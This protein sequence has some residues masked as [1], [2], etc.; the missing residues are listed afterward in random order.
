[1]EQDAYEIFTKAHR[2]YIKGIRNAISERLKSAY[3]DD[4]WERG[5]LPALGE[6]HRENL[7]RELEK[8][9]PE[10]V[11]EL[12][13]TT[14]F[15]RIVQRNHAMA[16]ADAF[17]NIDY[18][19]RLF[20]YISATRNE[21]AHV[22]DGQWTITATMHVVQI[23]R[24]ILISLRRKE[25][26]E[27]HRMFR[28]SLDQQVSIPE[29][30]LN[31][32]EEPPPDG[33]F[34]R[35]HS[36]GE[37]SLL[38]FWRALESYLVVESIVQP[39]SDDTQDTGHVTIL[40]K[41]TNTSPVSEGRPYIR[42][43][44]VRLETTGAEGRNRRGTNRSEWGELV[45]GQTVISECR[46]A[47]KGLAAVEFRVFGEVDL[48]SLF[49]VQRRNTLPQ[50]VVTPLLEQLGSQF[51]GVGIEDILNRVV[52][53]V[54]RIQPDMTL[55]EVSALRNELGHLKPLI[56]EKRE[57]L[58][59]FF[60]EYHISQESALGTPLREVI[61]L[62]EELETRKISAM[63]NAIGETDLESIQSVVLEIEQ[64][65]ISVL[66]AREAVRGRLKS[67]TPYPSVI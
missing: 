50:E 29:E 57:T 4:W 33:D 53:T 22:R 56:A 67:Q 23:M 60:G 5:V 36:V 32:S 55:A 13:D 11:A 20:R 21:W 1:M 12:L 40:V 26:L 63:D 64:L 49:Q 65:Q 30:F 24:E 44:N 54:A 43:R 62:L 7:E 51:E 41:I 38:E 25:A 31:V 47:E 10:D 9:V 42:F 3:G 2:V 46:S 6:N 19:Q 28:D 27:I 35:D 48:D 37:R 34:D 45:P 58:G 15:G 59:N 16:F 17:T 61:L 52:G 18:T 39:V 8:G 14:H 66:R